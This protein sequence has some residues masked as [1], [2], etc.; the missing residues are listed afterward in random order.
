MK[1]I[2]FRLLRAYEIEVRPQSI[3][4]GKA[5]MLLYM[6]SRVVTDL[7]DETVGSMNWT[8]E[9]YEV[10]NKLVCKI[11]IW[12]DDKNMFIYKSDTG[13]ESNIEAEKG[14]FSDCYKRCLSRWGVTE[15][16]SAPNI[17]IDDD[18]YGCKGY[19]V[20]QIGYD[21]FNRHIT[22][23]EIKNK[24]DKTVF[25]WSLN[26]IKSFDKQLITEENTN[27][28]YDI[29]VEFCRTEKP[30]ADGEKLKNFFKYY[31]TKLDNWNGTFNPEALWNK[32]L[33]RTK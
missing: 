9:F 30:Y 20:N 15:L 11:G 2:E 10:N 12:D 28:N 18:G 14:Q 22:S 4:N 29:L 17:I 7:L 21:V 33:E 32:W 23:I 5:T 25:V 3:K 16:Y 26:G 1:N 8:S 27:N 24:F 19:Y 6:N 13:S 31:K